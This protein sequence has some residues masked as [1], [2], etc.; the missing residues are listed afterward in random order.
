MTARLTGP[1]KLRWP[2]SSPTSR[3]IPCVFVMKGWKLY[4]NKTHGCLGKKTTLRLPPVTPR[5]AP[6]KTSFKRQSLYL[7]SPDISRDTL[8]L[9][10]SLSRHTCFSSVSSALPVTPALTSVTPAKA[11]G[12]HR[13]INDVFCFLGSRFRGNDAVDAGE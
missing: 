5:P 2:F 10:P 12:Q 13:L 1:D 6:A 3:D 9:T 11:G 8:F 4:E 7:P